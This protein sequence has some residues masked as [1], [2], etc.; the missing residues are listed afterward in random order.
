MNVRYERERNQGDF[1][2]FGLSNWKARERGTGRIRLEKGDQGFVWDVL[3]WTSVG[4]AS[5]NGD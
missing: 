1:E 4:H 3:K 5:G 2:A